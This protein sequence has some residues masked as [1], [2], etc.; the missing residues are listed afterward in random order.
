MI[1][2]LGLAYVIALAALYAAAIGCI[3][4]YRISREGHAEALR[5]LAAQA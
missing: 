3:A 4:L 5:K 1:D 2:N